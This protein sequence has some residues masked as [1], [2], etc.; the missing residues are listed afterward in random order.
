MIESIKCPVCHISP[1]PGTTLC[2]DCGKDLSM[3][4]YI[5]NEVD[6]QYNQALD[7]VNV[8]KN[9]EAIVL[10]AYLVQKQPDN[11]R[12]VN[13]L[14]KVYA[15]LGQYE[16]ARCVWLQALKFCPEEVSFRENLTV[17][18]TTIKKQ[19]DFQ[20]KQQEALF[21]QQEANDAKLESERTARLSDTRRKLRWMNA[22][23]LVGAFLAGVILL[24]IW[25][26]VLNTPTAPVVYT[27]PTETVSTQG[28]EV[29]AVILTDTPIP[30][31]TPYP[32]YTP[33]PTL[34]PTA[35]TVPPTATPDLHSTVMAS[36]ASE[37]NYSSLGL[38]VEQLDSNTVRVVGEI[39]NV[40][41]RYSLERFLYTIPGIRTV[42]MSG[43]TFGRFY[44][45]QA[46]DTFSEISMKV[47]GNWI[48]W[49]KIAEYNGMSFPYTLREGM[50]LKIP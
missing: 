42:D 20:R 3:L 41:E 32:T 23:K 7:L 10:L 13:L 24:F 27:N 34:Q 26:K 2:P 39:H 40:W 21:A 33:L 1:L 4:I 50:E 30:T 38:K 37:S 48:Y 19:A 47:Y 43:V 18:E 8:G 29:S 17:L 6:L 36:L 35:T 31:Y 14:G 16:T 12:V 28:T 5:Q 49:K 45:V 44:I 46:N 22:G 15:N 11:A 9:E 25:Q